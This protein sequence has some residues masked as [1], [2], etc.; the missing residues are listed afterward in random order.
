[1]LGDSIPEVE[2]AVR[3]GG[4]ESAELGVEGDGVNGVDVGHIVLGWV[5][6][7]FE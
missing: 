5:T 7:A 1:M 3:A 6:V 4:A 2:G